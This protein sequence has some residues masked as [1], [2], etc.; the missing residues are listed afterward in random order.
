MVGLHGLRGPSALHLVD[1]VSSLE[2]EIVTILHLLMMVNLVV[3]FQ[4]YIRTVWKK[5]VQVFMSMNMFLCFFKI[6]SRKL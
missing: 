3:E 4:L 2:N 5:N 6:F 1:L